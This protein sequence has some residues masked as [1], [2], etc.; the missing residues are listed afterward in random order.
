MNNILLFTPTVELD[1][2][3]FE[4]F[5]TWGVPFGTASINHIHAPHYIAAAPY[6]DWS[7]NFLGHGDQNTRSWLLKHEYR[8]AGR[9]VFSR[10]RGVVAPN[11][12][13]RD[14]LIEAG[15]FL[16]FAKAYL[17]VMAYYRNLRSPAR[18]MVGAL[19]TLEKSLR[20]LNSGDNN[21]SNLKCRVFE[22]AIS[23]LEETD[24][25]Q[26]RKY[27][28]GK[29]IEIVAGMLQTGYSS[30]T[31]RFSGKGFNLL[32]RPFSFSSTIRQK[33]RLR[34]FTLNSSD[35]RAQPLPRITNEE[36]TAVGIA[37]QKS[38]ATFGVKDATTFVASVAGL[39]LT[40]VSMR[41]SDLLTLRRDAIYKDESSHE[42]YRIR[43]SR[44]KTGASQDLPLTKKLGVLAESLFK[45]I[46]TYSAEAHSALDYYVTKFGNN[47]D[48]IDELYIPNDLKTIFSLRYIA[49]PDVYKALRLPHTSKCEILLP[50][51]LQRAGL[52]CF[53]FVKEP[54]DIWRNKETRFF[55]KTQYVTI[56]AVERECE[57]LG[58]DS[59][60]PSSIS[61]NLYISET[62]VSAFVKGGINR[63][64]YSLQKSL[65]STGLH[66]RKHIRTDQLSRHL[67]ARFKAAKQY[68]HWPYTTKDRNTRVND[69]L[70]VWPQ[71][72]R[73]PYSAVGDR[74]QLWWQPT[75]LTAAAL[76]EWINRSWD[77]GPP[78]LFAKLKIRLRNGSYP[79][80]TLHATRK[81][82]HTKALMAGVQEAF[83]DEL[84]GRKSGIQSDHYDLR[85]PHEILSRSID[86]FD[87]DDIYSV[88]GPAATKASLLSPADRVEFLYEN[89]APKHV[90]EI[91]GCASDWALDPCKQ[92]GD[93]MRCDQHLWRKGDEKRRPVIL[94]KYDYATKMLKIADEKLSKYETAPRSLVL[95]RKQLQDE[96]ERCRHIFSIEDDESIA[97]GT[98]VTFD[99]PSRVMS[100]SGRSDQLAKDNHSTS[101][102]K[103]SLWE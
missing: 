33:P 25:H 69:A 8:Q 91:G 26:G 22:H 17:N 98:I 53:W 35:M 95:Q 34:L 100:A 20:D 97:V 52:E 92:F 21:P 83:V 96:Q 5:T 28:I 29:E 24:L 36:V 90:T 47:F 70:L 46:L 65:F 102:D 44:P 51:T 68:P 55:S 76:G 80:L 66:A 77:G 75:L 38:L 3:R 23:L 2:D 16:E 49:F 85:T 30:K 60:F 27:D 103:N 42:R 73:N 32:T 58:L 99:A 10:G 45:N 71:L 87:P 48:A 4:Y 93:C 54:D 101:Y 50:G 79:S 14:A 86:L 43:L 84:A 7:P 31:F 19:I 40:T 67:L 41:V 13:N 56:G 94:M 64:G 82:H 88:V 6:F 81:F 9:S 62:D 63:H 89:A 61:R 74:G 72:A 1:C 37:Y 18:A 12:F 57:I 15:R 39:A 11:I 59:S 78:E